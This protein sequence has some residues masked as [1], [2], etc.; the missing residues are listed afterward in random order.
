MLRITPLTSDPP[1]PAFGVEGRLTAATTEELR[2]TC[3]PLLD[4]TGT[5]RLD[6][7]GLQF[8]D[9]AGA[10]LLRSFE[11]RGA[12][13][14]GPSS[15]VGAVLRA[16]SHDEESDLVAGLRRGDATAA[17]TVVRRFGGRMLATARRIVGNDDAAQD[18]VQD[19]FLSAFRSIDGFQGGSRLST[20][21]HRIVVNTALMKLRSK[22]RRPEESIEDLLPRF[23][24]DGHWADDPRP[25]DSSADVLL[26]RHETRRIVRA[27]IE[28]LPASHREVLLLR[29]VEEL[30][31]EE[32][33]AILGLTPAATRVRLHRARQALRTLLARELP[34]LASREG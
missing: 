7:S 33:A 16:G 10:T 32:T 11:R 12:T 3:E 34:V 23:A 26:E 13:I 2:R 20:W 25:W 8:L 30:D 17:E 21:L 14:T 31:T 9:D 29:D 19:A 28:R 15:F 22:R 6:V 5:L 4:T 27:A 18:V 24:D 1:P